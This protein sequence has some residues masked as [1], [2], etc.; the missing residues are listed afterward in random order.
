[1]CLPA[2]AGSNVQALSQSSPHHKAGASGAAMLPGAD[3]S[4]RWYT[5]GH[6]SALQIPSGP[7]A[8]GNL[9]TGSASWGGEAGESLRASRK[10]SLPPACLE[11]PRQ[12][13]AQRVLPKAA[14]V[15]AQKVEALISGD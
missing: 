2:A 6:P 8:Q 14:K 13:H 10:Q 4:A 12:H 1:M 15:Q 9:A 5:S 11:P 3:E 7:T